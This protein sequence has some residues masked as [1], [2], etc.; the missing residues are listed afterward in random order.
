MGLIKKIFGEKHEPIDVR[1]K[2]GKITFEEA[3]EEVAVGYAWA[4]FHFYNKTLKIEEEMKRYNTSIAPS[5]ARAVERL[6]VNTYSKEEAESDRSYLQTFKNYYQDEIDYVH[7]RNDLDL[8]C[9]VM[10][11]INFHGMN[12]LAGR[13]YSYNELFDLCFREDIIERVKAKDK[14]RIILTE[15]Y[16]YPSMEQLRTFIRIVMTV[17]RSMEKDIN[18]H[19]KHGFIIGESG[20]LMEKDYLADFVHVDFKGFV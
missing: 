14:A 3:M 13:D 12:E 15:G 17:H 7:T 5:L 8:M 10:S 4:A 9:G 19:N 11:Y 18:W 20:F 1:Y 6:E 2:K 16:D